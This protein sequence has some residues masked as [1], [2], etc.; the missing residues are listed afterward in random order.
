MYIWAQKTKDLIHCF[1][2]HENI[3]SVFDIGFNSV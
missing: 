1:E 2:Y 3:C